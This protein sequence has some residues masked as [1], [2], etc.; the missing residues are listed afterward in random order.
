MRF[1]ATTGSRH[2]RAIR[3]KFGSSRGG[4][5]TQRLTNYSV[6][7]VRSLPLGQGNG[8]GVSGPPAATFVPH[9]RKAPV[10]SRKPPV[11]RRPLRLRLRRAAIR[12]TASKAT[13]PLPGPRSRLTIIEFVQ[14]ITR[15]VCPDSRRACRGQCRLSKHPPRFGGLASGPGDHTAIR[16]ARANAQLPCIRYGP[17]LIGPGLAHTRTGAA[18]A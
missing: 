9:S 15:P 13:L 16:Q 14:R 11:R 4:E 12:M 7:G 1:D 3:G 18:T 17:E 10:A 6:R 8:A 2:D 5:P